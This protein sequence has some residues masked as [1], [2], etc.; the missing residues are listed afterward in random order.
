[1]LKGLSQA[2]GTAVG[3]IFIVGVLAKGGV[4]LRIDANKMGATGHNML[5]GAMEGADETPSSS[6]EF[7]YDPSANLTESN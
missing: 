5:Q 1:M 7:R 3:I 2:V 4:I 6:F